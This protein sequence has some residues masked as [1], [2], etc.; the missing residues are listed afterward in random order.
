MFEKKQHRKY[1]IDCRGKNPMLLSSPFAS[2]TS[3][4]FF[5]KCYTGR[6]LS[7]LR[8]FRVCVCA[9][10]N[11]VKVYAHVEEEEE[12][13]SPLCEREKRREEK[14]FRRRGSFEEWVRCAAPCAAIMKESPE[15]RFRG[16]FVLTWATHREFKCVCVPTVEWCRQGGRK[17]PRCAPTACLP[18]SRQFEPDGRRPVFF[19]SFSLCCASS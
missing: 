2:E 15:G 14:R 17:Q 4:F 18:T 19:F 16:H 11:V 6:W 13:E 8:S 1:P 12:E 3:F 5:S 7:F 9:E 10:T